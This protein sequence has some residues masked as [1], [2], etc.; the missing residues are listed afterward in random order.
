MFNNE[1]G[2]IG[3][4]KWEKY[5]LI[6]YQTKYGIYPEE[7]KEDAFNW[8]KKHGLRYHE[9]GDDSKIG[10]YWVYNTDFIEITIY[11]IGIQ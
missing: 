9:E 4:I 2:M 8:A 11:H 3:N 6:S 7:K 5:S 1:I 10:A